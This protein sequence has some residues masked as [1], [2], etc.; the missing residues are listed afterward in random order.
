[1]RR[2]LAFVFGWCAV[3]RC[4]HRRLYGEHTVLCHAH[5][6]MQAAVEYAD[7]NDDAELVQLGEGRT[8]LAFGDVGALRELATVPGLPVELSDDLER[9]TIRPRT[10]LRF[11]QVQRE[12][13]QLSALRFLH[14]KRY[15]KARRD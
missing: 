7:A 14:G 2:L 10:G 1:M 12:R 11:D 3:P 6:L 9:I 8:A 5:L 13:K 4:W 15:R